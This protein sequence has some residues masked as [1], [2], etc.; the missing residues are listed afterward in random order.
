MKIPEENPCGRGNRV[1]VLSYQNPQT[2]EHLQPGNATHM[3][4]NSYGI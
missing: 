3:F 1:R 4:T 2:N